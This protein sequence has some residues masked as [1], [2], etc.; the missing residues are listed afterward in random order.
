[1]NQQ[2]KDCLTGFRERNP[3][4][5]TGPLRGNVRDDALAVGAKLHDGLMPLLE[6]NPQ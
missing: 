3:I 6:L 1:V 4:D 5:I 2:L